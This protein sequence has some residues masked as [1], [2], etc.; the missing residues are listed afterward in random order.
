MSITATDLVVG[1]A[2][3]SLLILAGLFVLCRASVFQCVRG[4]ARLTDDGDFSNDVTSVNRRK[5]SFKVWASRSMFKLTA[6]LRSTQAAMEVGV[7]RAVKQA[8]PNAELE[9]LRL[10]HQNMDKADVFMGHVRTEANFILGNCDAIMPPAYPPE[11]ALHTESNIVLYKILYTTPSLRAALLDAVGISLMFS[12]FCPFTWLLTMQ[13]GIGLDM[14][15]AVR[16]KIGQVCAASST[17]V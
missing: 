14:L 6:S 9:A 15:E 5:K 4:T 16:S 3:G 1:L 12:S 13:G 11:R 7:R 17:R 2:S 10:F 8:D